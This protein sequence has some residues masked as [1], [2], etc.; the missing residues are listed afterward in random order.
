VATDYKPI[1]SVS[2]FQS[3]LDSNV[4][5]D[6]ICELDVRIEDLRDFLESGDGKKFHETRGAIAFARQVKEIFIV[7]LDN[8]KDDIVEEER[9]RSVGD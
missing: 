1:S 8:R 6:F 9:G 2:A 4:Y 3:F 5:E 7:L